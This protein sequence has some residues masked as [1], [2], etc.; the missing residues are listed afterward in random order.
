MGNGSILCVVWRNIVYDGKKLKANMDYLYKRWVTNCSADTAFEYLMD[1]S[2][3]NLD[4]KYT[5]GRPHDTFYIDQLWFDPDSKT[6]SRGCSTE[7]L[8]AMDM[9]GIYE[10]W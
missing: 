8:E 7:E 4:K 9:R 5:I 6:K 1:Y 10:C 3:K 2:Y